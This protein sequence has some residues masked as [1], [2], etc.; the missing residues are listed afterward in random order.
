MIEND[1]E[2]VQVIEDALLCAAQ[3]I[4]AMAQSRQA[5]WI[6]PNLLTRVMSHIHNAREY[7]REKDRKPCYSPWLG[8]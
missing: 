3:D 4:E 8:W 2:Q 6:N 7:M 5:I 1:A